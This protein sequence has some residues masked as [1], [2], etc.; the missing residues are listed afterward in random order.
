MDHLAAGT[1]AALS[2]S[3]PVVVAAGEVK[4][5]KSVAAAEVPA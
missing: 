5:A 3:V 4:G 2:A 1:V